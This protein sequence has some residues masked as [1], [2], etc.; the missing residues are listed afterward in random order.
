MPGAVEK[1]ERLETKATEIS[2]IKSVIEKHLASVEDP[3]LKRRFHIWITNDIRR[4]FNVKSYYNIPEDK[5]NEA[6]DFVRQWQ[7]PG[8]QDE[9]ELTKTGTE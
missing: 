4:K 7:I 1:L 5:V 6:V 2:I 3:I 9:D 8:S